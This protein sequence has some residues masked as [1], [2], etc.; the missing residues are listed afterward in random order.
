MST[1][2]RQHF[3]LIARSIAD[4]ADRFKSNTAH[5]EFAA[6]VARELAQTNSAFDR[7]RF[8]LAAMPSTHVGTRH[9]NAWERVARRSAAR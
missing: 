9:A 3:E 6:D 2:T 1:M 8:I 4:S 7:G 5:A